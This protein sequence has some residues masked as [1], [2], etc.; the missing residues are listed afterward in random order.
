[1]ENDFEIAT[2]ELIFAAD[3]SNN[4]MLD[5][6][7][8]RRLCKENALVKNDE[9]IEEFFKDLDTNEDGHISYKEFIAKLCGAATLNPDASND[10]V[11]ELPSREE[12]TAG[13]EEE[14]E[15][16]RDPY[17]EGLYCLGKTF[18]NARHAYLSI[19]LSALD[20]TDINVS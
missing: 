5:K 11:E 6:E 2:L 9:D 15:E 8:I 3:T 14:A 10:Q 1:M 16:E 7:E 4:G 12:E 13:A 20:L 17:R 19:R 18:N